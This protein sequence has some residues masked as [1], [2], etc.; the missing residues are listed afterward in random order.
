MSPRR[1]PLVA[2]VLALVALAAACDSRDMPDLRAQDVAVITTA[3]VVGS[4][5]G[6]VGIDGFMWDY[7]PCFDH[8]APNEQGLPDSHDFDQDPYFGACALPSVAGQPQWHSYTE[9]VS[10]SGGQ[11][12]P[13]WMGTT[14]TCR[15]TTGVWC[16]QGTTISHGWGR[17]WTRFA[18]ELYPDDPNAAGVRLEVGCCSGAWGPFTFT[19]AIGDIT[20]PSPGTPGT[21]GVSGTVRGV[22]GAQQ[23]GVDVFQID[24]VPS[25]RSS[26]GVPLASF[27]STHNGARGGNGTWSV[28]AVYDGEYV[29]FVTDKARPTRKV[30]VRFRVPERTTIDLD[31]N[32]ACFGLTGVYDPATWYLNDT[33]TAGECA[34]LW[35]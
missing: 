12:G 6:H 11:L 18:L 14:G 13:I 24:E 15:D 33:L 35:S 34:A 2:L 5:S 26:G 8:R 1:A 16:Q 23:I 10:W 19:D 4:S 20:L 30:V 25:S 32:A 31:R 28:P 22:S 29:A 3:R 7:N 9:V 17:K 27:A 21:H